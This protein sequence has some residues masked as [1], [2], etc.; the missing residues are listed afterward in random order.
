MERYDIAI[1]GAGPAGLSAGLY[2]ARALKKC[3]MIEQSAVGGLIFAVPAAVMF[4]KHLR[5][6]KRIRAGKEVRFSF[7]WKGKKEIERITR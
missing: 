1:I 4:C 3:V 7:L 2:A 5:N 6:L